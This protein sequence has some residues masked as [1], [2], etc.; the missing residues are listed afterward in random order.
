[1]SLCP[2]LI[3]IGG[4]VRYYLIAAN[5]WSHSPSHSARLAPLRIVKKGFNRSMKREIKRLRASNR[6]VSYWISFLEV[7]AGDCKVAFSCRGFASIPLCVTI[8]PRNLPAL[9]PNAHFSGLSFM[10]YSRRRSK[11]CWRCVTWSWRCLDF[12]SITSI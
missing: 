1:M 6:P 3:R 9:T 7:G 2:G 11:A 12:T 10:P 8:K 5:A 4:S